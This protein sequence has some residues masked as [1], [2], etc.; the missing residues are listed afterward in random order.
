MAGKSGFCHFFVREN[1]FSGAFCGFRRE[2][3]VP[4]FLLFVRKTRQTVSNGILVFYGWMDLK[5]LIF[6]SKFVFSMGIF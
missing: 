6:A 3:A 5:M 1:G 4:F 2:A